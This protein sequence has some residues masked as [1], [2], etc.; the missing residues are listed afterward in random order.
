MP[1]KKRDHRQ[2]CGQ[3]ALPENMRRLAK[4][5]TFHFRC[6]PGVPCFTECCRQL[7]LALTPYDVLR[8][9]K[10]LGLSGA[11]F[12]K[13]YA[14]IEHLEGEAF[15]Q[16]YLGMVDDGRA[17]CPFVSTAGCAVYHDR[18]GACRTYPLG[19]GAYRTADGSIG[20]MHV[21]LTEPHCRG[22]LETAAQTADSWQADQDLHAY[23]AMNDELLSLLQDQRLKEGW[24]PDGNEIELYLDTLYR[25]EHFKARALA[26]EIKG[27]QII[28]L[29]TPVAAG[30]DEAFLRAGIK[31]LHHEFFGT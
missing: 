18:P 6:H 15:P 16:V 31:W 17:S 3:P 10:N 29:E 14:V 5:E 27:L 20:E 9:A 23:N 2:Q 13:Q 11:E 21:L 4:D 30:N 28:G 24:R 19:R 7:D 25:L 8:L 1:C 12:L 22:F 26:G